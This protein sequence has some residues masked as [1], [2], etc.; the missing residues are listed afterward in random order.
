M[1]SLKLPESNDMLV[2]HEIE[3]DTDGLKTKYQTMPMKQELSRLMNGHKR[4]SSCFTVSSSCATERYDEEPDRLDWQVDQL[5]DAHVKIYELCNKYKKEHAQKHFDHIA[6]NY[7]G[8]Y[9]RM[10]Y[11]D[12]KYVANFANKFALKNGV[13]PASASVIDFGCGTG[14]V[15]QYMSE[16]GFKNI[17]GLD[18]SPQMLEECSN[19][20]V[21][22][23]L[24]EQELGNAEEFPNNFK[25]KFDIVTCAGLIN[26]NHMDYLL[27]EE[28]MLTVKQGGLVV[29][30]AR[31]S[32]MG[33]YWYD[34]VIKK[35]KEDCRWKLLATDTFFKYDKLE[36]VSIG[37]FSRT[38]VKVFVFQKT[39]ENIQM[40]VSEINDKL[41]NFLRMKSLQY[42]K[43]KNT[44]F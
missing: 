14:L 33:K 17:I 1:D 11:P 43:K 13:N 5:T 40:H 36:Q 28:M 27:F 6:S 32:F 8:M 38:P 12:P 35:M 10:G 30:A 3:S 18:V 34:D 44:N 31:F 42:P 9:L 7:E 19:K 29:F 22:K 25:N 23:E 20:G 16:F 41:R 21:Y 26:N 4:N 39:Q 2:H 24:F 37:R 15:G